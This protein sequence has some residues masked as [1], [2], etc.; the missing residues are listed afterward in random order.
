MINKPDVF[1]REATLNDKFLTDQRLTA[2][3]VPFLDR[4][5][6]DLSLAAIDEYGTLVAGLTGR[7]YWNMAIIDLWTS[8]GFRGDGLGHQLMVEA[9]FR[10]RALGCAVMLLSTMS[11]QGLNFYKELHFEV[12]S[13]HDLH[14]VDKNGNPVWVYFLS[15]RLGVK[16]YAN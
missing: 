4:N 15:K 13:A 9:E 12:D 10:A 3:N 8:D 7:A 5:E 1:F 14:I 6:H 11:W 2:F 16:S